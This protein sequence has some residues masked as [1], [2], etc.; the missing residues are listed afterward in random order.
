MNHKYVVT[1]TLPR[2]FVEEPLPDGPSKG[3][4]I[5]KKDM[6]YMKRDYY[7]TR[8]WDENG[9]PLEKTLKRLRINYVRSGQ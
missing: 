1:D 2:R 3:H 5:S 4:C 8:G 6:A 9:V 7:K